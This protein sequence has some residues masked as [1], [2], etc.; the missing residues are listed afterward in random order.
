MVGTDEGTRL[1]PGSDTP[2]PEHDERPGPAGPAVRFTPTVASLVAGADSARRHAAR[3]DAARPDA[4]RPGAA[5]AT[6]VLDTAWTPADGDPPAIPLRPA[7]ATVLDRHELF[8]AALQLTDD[9]AAATDALS[10]FEVEGV[11]YWYRFRESV[12]HWVHE[13]LL[14]AKALDALPIEWTAGAVVEVPAAEVALADILRAR[15]LVVVTPEPAD[16]APQAAR[17]QP[18]AVSRPGTSPRFRARWL[19][20]PLRRV[21]RRGR[22]GPQATPTPRTIRRA[23]TA[24]DERVASLLLERLRVLEEEDPARRVLAISMPSVFQ[25][26]GGAKRRDAN[27]DS[28]V[29]AL[30][31]RGLDV[32]TIGWGM[33]R[34][35]EADTPLIESSPRLLPN[36]LLGDR[37]ARPED[38]GLAAAAVAQVEGRL[39]ATAAPM[40]IA[41]LPLT[42]PLQRDLVDLCDRTLRSEIGELHRAGRFLDDLQ[43]RVIVMTHEGHRIGWL[44]AA[45]RRGIPTF[46][47]QHGVLYPAHPGYPDR[48]DARIALPTKTFV[49]GPFEGRVLEGWGYDQ[50]RIEVVG[51]PRLD[52]D[53]A[54][55]PGFEHDVERTAVRRELALDEWEQLVVVSTTHL[56]YLRRSHVVVGL[57]RV[58][59][60]PLPGVHL[61]FKQH[62]GERD[63]G[64]YRRLLEGLAR[65][66]GYPA[67]RMTV[68]REIDL[69]RL[70]RAA[71]AHL[72]QFSTVLSDAV[73][74][75][76]PNLIAAVG[77]FA[78]FLDY[79]GEGVAQPVASC[80]DLANALATL[81]APESADR[82]AFLRDHFRE[83][84]AGER[85]AEVIGQVIDP[86]A[87]G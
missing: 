68:V 52:L 73:V 46:A 42:E 14:W 85:V 7:L 79:V 47:V 18:A 38:L 4:A 24:E 54:P 69:M 71:D 34:N 83:G 84:A 66:G 86:V 64:P 10:L 11:T 39:R 13:R 56:G 21:L 2:A 44:V 23:K 20:G 15:G 61:V 63:D 76:A 65:A 26:V 5:A 32:V 60:G 49:Y 16:P 9:W 19:T 33:A 30:E 6:V 81:R 75:D 58:L 59:D 12:W 53:P 8:G 72:G 43:P 27:L 28:V 78:P 37:W 50:D 22:S 67:P 55:A 31:A 1:P 51:S 40:V 45:A 35:S 87:V 77:R 41:G 80:D 74:A 17:P 82:E 57:A 25:S 70:L 62:P 48:R 36:Y 29:R 3:P